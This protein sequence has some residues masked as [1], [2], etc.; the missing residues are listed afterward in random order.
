MGQWCVLLQ[1]VLG[2]GRPLWQSRFSKSRASEWSRWSGHQPIWMFAWNEFADRRPKRPKRTSTLSELSRKSQESGVWPGRC[3]G[4]LPPS[5]TLDV[6]E[7]YLWTS[8]CGCLTS[9]SLAT[10]LDWSTALNCLRMCLSLGAGRAPS[11]APSACRSASTSTRVSGCPRRA[12]GG[13]RKIPPFIPLPPG[14]P[15][16][17]PASAILGNGVKIAGWFRVYELQ[18]RKGMQE[19]QTEKE[20]M[21][22]QQ[23]MKIRTD[24]TRKIKSMGRMDA[25]NSWWSAF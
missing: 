7:Q 13:K 10:T 3:R 11:N 23:R 8:P 21:R 1:P 20:E 12:H 2:R 25:K 5:V 17:D 9:R 15:D 19:S 22:Q 24:M 18:R 16:P 6:A 14:L 4:G